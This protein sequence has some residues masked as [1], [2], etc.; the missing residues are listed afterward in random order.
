MNDYIKV[1]FNNKLKDSIHHQHV[2]HLKKQEKRLK[3]R[4]FKEVQHKDH[5]FQQVQ[6]TEKSYIKEVSDKKRSVK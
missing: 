4:L 3:I 5:R 2:K 6:I 1:Q